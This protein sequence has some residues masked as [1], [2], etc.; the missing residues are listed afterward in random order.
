MP[1][2]KDPRRKSLLRK[3]AVKL[4][5]HKT[6]M[7]L[8]DPFWAALKEIA[9]A[10]GTTISQLI[11]AIDSERHERHHPNL[12]SAIRLFVLEYYRQQNWGGAVP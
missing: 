5:D 1:Q 9:A 3:R 11:T 12:S 7:T 8:E 6:S 4:D 2:P 10:Q